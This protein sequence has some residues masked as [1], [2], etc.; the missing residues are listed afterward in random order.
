MPT[1]TGTE[2]NCKMQEKTPTVLVGLWGKNVMKGL[3]EIKNEPARIQH[4]FEHH[5]YM[6]HNTAYWV[7]WNGPSI[8]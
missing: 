7:K 6:N 8:K 3:V 2:T 1:P 5:Q 4:T